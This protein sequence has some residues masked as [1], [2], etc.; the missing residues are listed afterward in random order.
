M[1][2]PLLTEDMHVFLDVQSIT[3]CICDYAILCICLVLNMHAG[4]EVIAC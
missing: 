2:T 4:D 1:Q 3:V